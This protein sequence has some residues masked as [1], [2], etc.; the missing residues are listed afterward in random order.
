MIEELNEAPLHVC[1]C[2]SP[3]A[4]RYVAHCLELDLIGEGSEKWEAISRLKK[5][6]EIQYRVCEDKDAVFLAYDID[7][8]WIEYHRAAPLGSPENTTFIME[9]RRRT[10]DAEG[11]RGRLQIDKTP[12]F[13]TNKDSW[14]NEYPL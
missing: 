12:R 3:K 11:V 1:V 9:K 5:T 8:Q 2:C 10:S 6:I 14:C 7:S 4:P 13:L